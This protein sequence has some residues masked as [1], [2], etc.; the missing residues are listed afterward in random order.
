MVG[1]TVETIVGY[2][3][4]LSTPERTRLYKILATEAL[5]LAGANG[6]AAEPEK[7]KPLPIPVPD[8]EPSRRWIAPIRRSTP[9]N[10]WRWTATG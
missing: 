9:G 4:Q 7:T 1:I 3:N 10:G 8:P 5:K 2:I 6:A